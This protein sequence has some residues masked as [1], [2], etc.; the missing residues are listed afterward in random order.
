MPGIKLHFVHLLHYFFYNCILNL[1]D[2]NKNQNAIKGPLSFRGRH[3]VSLQYIQR[4]I[5]I[6]YMHIT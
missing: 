6:L 4:Y 2:F 5:R 3:P 1:A